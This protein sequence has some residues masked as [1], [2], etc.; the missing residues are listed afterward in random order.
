M[1]RRHLL[2]SGLGTRWSDGKTDIVWAYR[3]GVLPLLPGE[4]AS[5]IIGRESEPLGDD[6]VLN[7]LPHQVYM[8]MGGHCS[9]RRGKQLIEII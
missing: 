6:G 8:I 5:R 1:H 3:S 7:V 2:P 4:H 9:R